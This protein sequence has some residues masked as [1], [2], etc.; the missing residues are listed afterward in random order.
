MVQDCLVWLLDRLLLELGRKVTSHLK[1]ED[2]TEY[3]EMKK[4]AQPMMR[5]LKADHVA[6]S[7]RA[8]R[9]R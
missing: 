9:E 3:I 5:A 7:M 6:T 8:E 1:K 2:R 4:A